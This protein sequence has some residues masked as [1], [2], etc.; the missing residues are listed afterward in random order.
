[1]DMLTFDNFVRYLKEF[2]ILFLNTLQVQV[3]EKDL[4][5]I[6]S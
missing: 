6:Q 3:N 4:P 2:Q 5:K 1:M